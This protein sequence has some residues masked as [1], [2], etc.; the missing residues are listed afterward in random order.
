MPGSEKKLEQMLAD[1]L[2]VKNNHG[3]DNDSF[4]VLLGLVN[5]MGMINL[6][7]GRMTRDTRV[8]DT[9]RAS[10]D[11]NPFMGM[12]AGPRNRQPAGEDK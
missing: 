5:L 1:L 8:E 11:K 3:L 7:E 10:P 12:L 9:R 2:K 6:M 4:L